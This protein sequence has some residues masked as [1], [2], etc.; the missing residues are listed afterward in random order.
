MYPAHR[1]HN[2]FA[3]YINAHRT[4]GNSCNILVNVNRPTPHAFR[5]EQLY[6]P[7]RITKIAV[8]GHSFVAGLRNKLEKEAKLYNPKPS[9]QQQLSL[10][11]YQ[12]EPV[13]VSHPSIYNNDL[14]MFDEELEDK[15]LDAIVVDC[16]SNDLCTNRPASKILRDI[17]YICNHWITELDVQCV[18]VCDVLHR[19]E[20]NPKWSD[21]TVDQYNEDV[22]TYNQMLKEWIRES[23]TKIQ[24]WDHKNLKNVGILGQDGVHPSTPVSS[25]R[26]QRSIRGA[27]IRSD[28]YTRY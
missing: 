14:V 19:R 3:P 25:W 10:E 4:M 15:G 2:R 26:Y 24:P 16:G 13:L 17:K 12:I 28:C 27:I 9:L 1:P 23:S 20:I 22:D 11:E 5:G 21:K 8:V 6:G 18:V 7:I